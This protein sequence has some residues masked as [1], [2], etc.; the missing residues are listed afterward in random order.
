MK[1]RE[2]HGLTL[3][4]SFMWA[5]NLSSSISPIA[6]DRNNFDYRQWDLW[7]GKAA[8]TPDRRFVSACSYRLAVR[9]GLRSTA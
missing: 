9:Q 4:S 7:R 8:L 2:W 6:N 1:N 3:L 5:K